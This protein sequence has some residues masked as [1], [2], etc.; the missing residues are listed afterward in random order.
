MSAQQM[1]KDHL[2]MAKIERREAV[3]LNLHIAGLRGDAWGLKDK[4]RQ[5][6]RKA[7]FHETMANSMKTGVAHYQLGDCHETFYA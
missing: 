6:I 5:H 2:A 4:I 1:I 7:E 3:A